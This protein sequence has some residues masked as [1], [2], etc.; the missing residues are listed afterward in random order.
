MRITEWQPVAKVPKKKIVLFWGRTFELENGVRNW[1]ME[2]GYIH[3]YDGGEDWYWGGSLLRE[4]DY[5]PTHWI[6]LPEPPE[7]E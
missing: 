7:D 4:Y 5:F 2:T 6:P 3:P 1:K